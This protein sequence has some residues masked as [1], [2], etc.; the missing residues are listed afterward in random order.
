MDFLSKIK[1]E[2]NEFEEE[3]VK[4][5]HFKYLMKRMR[6]VEDLF[7]TLLSKKIFLYYSEKEEHVEG[8][9]PSFLLNRIYFSLNDIVFQ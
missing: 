8:Y 3:V 5:V 1:R 2:K 6:G 9:S 7:Y 4:S